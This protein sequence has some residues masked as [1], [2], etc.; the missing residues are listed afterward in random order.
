MTKHTVSQKIICPCCRNERDWLQGTSLP[1]TEQK[2]SRAN[3]S[4]WWN[5]N[6]GWSVEEAFKGKLQWACRYC[7]KTKRAIEADPVL[8]KVLR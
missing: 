2:L 7:V 5:S 6:L 8:Q 4:P 1:Q 3:L